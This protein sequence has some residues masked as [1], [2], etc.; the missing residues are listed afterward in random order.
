MTDL[1]AGE[2]KAR[3]RS[4][5]LAVRLLTGPRGRE[6]ALRLLI[7]E[8]SGGDPDALQEAEREFGKLPTLDQRRILSSYLAVA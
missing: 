2:R 7:A 5:R 3:L 8:T 4:L 6:A 1:D